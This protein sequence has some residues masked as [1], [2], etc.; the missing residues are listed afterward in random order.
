[1]TAS[2]TI[3]TGTTFVSTSPRT[4]TRLR[5]ADTLQP[6]LTAPSRTA[7]FTEENTTRLG[8]PLNICSTGEVTTSNASTTQFHQSHTSR[9]ITVHPTEMS[10]TAPPVDT[11]AG[12]HT[13]TIT[14]VRAETT[15]SIESLTTRTTTM[16]TRILST[17]PIGSIVSTTTS[18]LQTPLTTLDDTIMSDLTTSSDC[19][20]P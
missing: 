13:I 7:A 12:N 3:S 15:E 5:D 2:T 11:L 14:N 6:S 18:P 10:R 16:K 20:T 4:S 8:N 9:V 17:T 19:S 1:M